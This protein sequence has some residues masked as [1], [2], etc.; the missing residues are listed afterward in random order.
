MNEMNRVSPNLKARCESYKWIM[1]YVSPFMWL[2]NPFL[3]LV[4]PFPGLI[5]PCVSPLM[6][7][8]SRGGPFKKPLVP[9]PFQQSPDLGAPGMTRLAVELAR[10]GVPEACRSFLTSCRTSVHMSMTVTS[11]RDGRGTAV[12]ALDPGVVQNQLHLQS[13]LRNLRRMTCQ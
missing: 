5:S 2:I 12:R 6:G 1:G 9:A 10:F 8:T 3:G 7:P 13:Q 11:G 4:S